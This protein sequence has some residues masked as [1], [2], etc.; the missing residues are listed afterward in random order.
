M[1]NRKIVQELY[2]KMMAEIR[3]HQPTTTVPL[4]PLCLQPFVCEE[5]SPFLPTADHIVPESVGGAI[6]TLTSKHCNNTH[7]S[8]LDSH[9]KKAM[10]AFDFLSGKGTL[11]AV[12]KNSVGHISAN[13]DWNDATPVKINIIGEK[14]SHPAAIEDLHCRFPIDR[15]LSFTL[16][17]GFIPEAFWRAILRVGYLAAFHQFGYAYALSK[18]GAQ[19]REAL[20]A[21]FL[22]NNVI[23]SAYPSG[24][25][26]V[27]F[28]VHCLKD[29]IF[30]LFRVQSGRTRW[31]AVMLPGFEGCAWEDLEKVSS[32]ASRLRMVLK[33]GDD[34]ELTVGFGPEPIEEIRG[35]QFP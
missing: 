25:L 9:L 13:M 7:G 11:P 5:D 12:I 27:P 4:C 34:P 8:T 10:D 3:A 35:L 15:K 29:G 31:L 24:D 33:R 32:V 20:S 19:V 21:R 26:E 28:L 1:T 17:F 16:S 22:P 30:V 6:C 18:G 14:A 2:P 23:L